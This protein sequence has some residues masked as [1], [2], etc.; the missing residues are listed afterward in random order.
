[1]HYHVATFIWFL[2]KIDYLASYWFM[3]FR[4]FCLLAYNSLIITS[5]T[6]FGFSFN[7]LNVLVSLPSL[8][9]R[10]GIVKRKMDLNMVQLMRIQSSEILGLSISLSANLLFLK[11]EYI[12][13]LLLIALFKMEVCNWKMSYQSKD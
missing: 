13:S 2:K 10:E 8:A 11:K 5:C 6:N 9:R 12:H 7:E 4:I 3:T 1:M